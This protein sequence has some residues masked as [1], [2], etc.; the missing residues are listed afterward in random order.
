[1]KR[2]FLSELKANRFFQLTQAHFGFDMP[3]ESSKNIKRERQFIL[4]THRAIRTKLSKDNGTP[5]AE[6]SSYLTDA[7]KVIFNTLLSRVTLKHATDAGP[8][9]KEAGRMM[10]LRVRE[11]D[12]EV[13]ASNRH[14]GSQ[15]GM[16]ES[17]YFVMGLGEHNPPGFVKDSS[18]LIT[19]QLDSLIQDTP[20]VAER[21]WVS[22]HLSEYQKETSW[23]VK[24][25]NATLNVKYT[26]DNK[27]H[28]TLCFEEGTSLEWCSTYQEELYSGPLV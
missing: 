6:F 11:K 27:K 8:Q 15:M 12:D 16:D 26:Q 10:S 7:E 2:A 5:W 14:T 23:K 4:D 3:T 28:Y 17:L 13:A 1:M 19:A 9:I 21:L 25:G 24:V 22:N 20:A 18:Y